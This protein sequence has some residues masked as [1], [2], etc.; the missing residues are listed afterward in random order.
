MILVREG[1]ILEIFHLLQQHLLPYATKVE[2]AL[3]TSAGEALVRHF[4][5]SR[6]VPLRSLARFARLALQ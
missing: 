5:D 4:K 1:L 6:R 3:A 2:V